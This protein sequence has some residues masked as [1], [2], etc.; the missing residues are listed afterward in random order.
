ML[1]G[2]IYFGYYAL[3]QFRLKNVLFKSLGLFHSRDWDVMNYFN[4]AYVFA[5]VVILTFSFFFYYA[6]AQ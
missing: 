5:L 4:I 2:L 6:A 1:P 3:Q